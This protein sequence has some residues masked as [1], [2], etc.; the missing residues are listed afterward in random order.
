MLEFVRAWLL[1]TWHMR[2]CMLGKHVWED[3]PVHAER[4]CR[5]C[6]AQEKVVE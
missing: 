6:P 4:F 5:W 1:Q 3:S 2:Q